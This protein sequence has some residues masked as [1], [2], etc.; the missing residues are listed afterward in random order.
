MNGVFD[1][2]VN[3]KKTHDYIRLSRKMA[4]EERI[5]KSQERG[6]EEKSPSV[7]EGGKRCL[8]VE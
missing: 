7:E 4:I 2:R 5:W 1:I 8:Y 6:N 3:D